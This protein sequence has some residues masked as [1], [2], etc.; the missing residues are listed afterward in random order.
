MEASTTPAATEL[1]RRA[2]RVI[3]LFVATLALGIA[4]LA[5]FA[6]D[7]QDIDADELASRSGE[8]RAF[9]VGDYV[10]VVLY[11]ILSP[12]AILRFGSVLGSGTPPA[13][14][15]LAAICLAGAGVFDLTENTLLFAATSSASQGAVDAAHAVAIPKVAL[16]VAGTLLA[17]AANVRAVQVLRER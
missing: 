15:R 17:I 2:V 9:L 5:F 7:I 3:A 14:I 6:T 12:I 4:L 10:F 1:R 11:A 16:F 13:W 8:A